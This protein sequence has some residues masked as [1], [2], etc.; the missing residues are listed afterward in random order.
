DLPATLDGVMTPATAAALGG[1]FG[2][3]EL[4]PPRAGADLVPPKA[5]TFQGVGRPIVAQRDESS[6]GDLNVPG[7]SL[8]PSLMGGGDDESSFSEVHAED[9]LQLDAPADH[10]LPSLDGGSIP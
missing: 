4:P 8:P 10:R 7:D 9:A 2:D 3:I 6:F 5:P 1:G